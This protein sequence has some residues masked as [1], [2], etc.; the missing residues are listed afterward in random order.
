MR[1]MPSGQGPARRSGPGGRT[2]TRGA[3][4]STVGVRV[5]PR[6]FASRVGAARATDT[7][8]SANRPAAARRA[9]LGGAAKRIAAPTSRG[10]TRRATILLLV[11]A[12]LALGYA[13]PI[14][15][16]LSQQSDIARMRAAQAA[17]RQHINDLTDQVAKWQDDEYIRIQAR[18][19][20]YY[21][22]PG[23][24]PLVVLMD[25]AGASRDAGVDPNAGKKQQ[26]GPWY[27][28]LWSSIQ[29]AN[30]K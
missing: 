6:P 13:Y 4:R 17:Q 9:A 29:V 15:V 20:L 5:E 26:A 7:G 12:A 18:R 25:T 27:G 14:R 2:S 1:R 11:F 19:R 23:E 8:R 16:Y 24:I 30:G 22:Y 3:A 21:V 10:L 28:K